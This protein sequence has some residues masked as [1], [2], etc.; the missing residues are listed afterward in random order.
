MRKNKV[1]KTILI[2]GLLSIILGSK[3]VFSEPGSEKDPLVS[4]S[5][6]EKRIDQL[7]YYIDEKLSNGGENNNLSNSFEVVEISAGQ[8]IIGKDG[9]EII[10]R[11]GRGNG[12]GRAKIVALGKD[13]LSDLT[14]GKDLIRDEEVPLNHLLIVPRD[15]GRGVYAMNDSVFLVKGRYEIR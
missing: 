5:Y 4:L 7:K 10:L 6:L 1:K 9:T 2:L 11:G 12:P 8:S 3:V 14:V 15:D 13:G